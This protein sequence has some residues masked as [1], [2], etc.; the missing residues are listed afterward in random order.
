METYQIILI[1]FV[2]VVGAFIIYLK[3]GL[4]FVPQEKRLVIY[5]AGHYHGIAGPGPVILWRRI[6]TE[7]RTINVR[8]QPTTYTVDNLFIY[9]VPIGLTFSIWSAFEPVQATGN[10]RD[11]LIR[12]VV[13]SDHE[14]Q[15]QVL[16]MLRNILVQEL[17]AIELAHPL[18]A[19]ASIGEKLLPIIPGLPI[20]NGMLERTRTRLQTD[21]RTIGFVLNPA[22]P[23]L[24]TGLKPPESVSKGF[25]RERVLSFLRPQFPNLPDDVLA[26][27]YTS[28]EKLDL[29]TLQRFVV[30]NEGNLSTRIEQRTENA[31]GGQT[32]ITMQTP[33]TG[34]AA[35]MAAQPPVNATPAAPRPAPAPPPATDELRPS[36]LTVLKRVPRGAAS[37]QRRAA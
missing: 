30:Q 33:M 34:D 3:P 11:Q 37:D 35:N 21:M 31:Q 32:R 4:K 36:D 10:D 5:R 18:P 6:D 26:Q 2:L 23:I 19:T 22:R 12:L 15:S 1:V 8:E 27:L 9:G 24:I 29:P 16:L 25:D 13:F 7:E 14:R 17:G 28:I 20:C